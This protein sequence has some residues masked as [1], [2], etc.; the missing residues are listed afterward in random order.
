M[1][2]FFEQTTQKIGERLNSVQFCA[3]RNYPYPAHFHSNLEML[4]VKKGPYPVAINGETYIIDSGEIV[5]F[6]QY[7]IHEYLDKPTEFNEDRTLVI[8]QQYLIS[9][10]AKRKNKKIVSPVIKSKEACDKVIMIIDTFIAP[11][12]N[13]EQIVA[14]AINLILSVILKELRFSD[15]I[16]YDANLLKNILS[17]IYNNYRDDISLFSISKQLGYSPEHISR[18]FHKHS[19]LSIRDYVNQLRIEYIQE[20]Q[21]LSGKSETELIFDAGFKNPSTYYRQRAK[22]SSKDIRFFEL[23]EYEISSPKK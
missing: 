12:L 23:P 17:V 9:F 21:Q 10:N 22:H 3:N 16:M 18:V 6:D 8:P 20:Q 13:D 2:A 15:E 19:K 7:D 4:C 5:I 14:P 1:K 11:D